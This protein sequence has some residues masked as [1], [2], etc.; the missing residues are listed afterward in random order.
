MIVAIMTSGPCL[1]LPVLVVSNV[2][3]SEARWQRA[4]ELR[5]GRVHMTPRPP[6]VTY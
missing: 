1:S 4:R 3:L 5:C 2:Y 6:T